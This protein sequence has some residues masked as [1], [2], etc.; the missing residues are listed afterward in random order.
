MIVV[1][2][3]YG[4]DKSYGRAARF[5]DGSDPE[6]CLKSDTY[7]E[8]TDGAIGIQNAQRIALENRKEGEKVWFEG[9]FDLFEIE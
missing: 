2:Y 6:K 5:P 1:S 8:L 7:Q 3:I 9:P 4:G